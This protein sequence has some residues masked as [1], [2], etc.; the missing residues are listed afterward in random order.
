MKKNR[1]GT[2]KK[3]TPRPLLA[4]DTSFFAL[5]R[6]K[7]PLIHKPGMMGLT[8]S[9]EIGKDILIGVRPMGKILPIQ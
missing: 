8:S 7:E 1:L 4:N 2:R 9:T 3:V 6:H 5:D